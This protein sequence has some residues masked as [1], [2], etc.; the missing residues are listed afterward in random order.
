MKMK[1]INNLFK[2]HKFNNLFIMKTKTHFIMA[3]FL[4]VVCLI[5]NSCKSYSEDLAFSKDLMSE[6]DGNHAVE[7]HNTLTTNIN[8]ILEADVVVEPYDS[9]TENVGTRAVVDKGNNDK[10]I[11]VIVDMEFAKKSKDV[12]VSSIRSYG[13]MLELQTKYDVDFYVMENEPVGLEAVIYVS[14]EETLEALMPLIEQS[15]N[16]LYRKGFTDIEIDEMLA[17]NNASPAALVP[18]VLLLSED[19]INGSSDISRDACIMKSE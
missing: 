10:V 19:E 7:F 2:S 12:N 4:A 1:R 15:K 9:S 8:S 17:E 18:L 5:M 11:P 6:Y 16:Y 3:G 13:D 14:E